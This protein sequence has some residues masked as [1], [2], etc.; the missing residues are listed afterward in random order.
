MNRIVNNKEFYNR[1]LFPNIETKTGKRLSETH[2]RYIVDQVSNAKASI[3]SKLT[4]G[5]ALKELTDLFITKLE[6][7]KPTKTPLPEEVDTREHSKKI[8]G[9]PYDKSIDT[10]NLSKEYLDVE[11]AKE[12]NVTKFLGVDNLNDIK[13]L[14]KISEPLPP[15]DKTYILLDTKYRILDSDGTKK[16]SWNISLTLNNTQGVTN[17]LNEL[18]NITSIKVLPFRIPNHTDFLTEFRRITLLIEELVSQS[19]IGQESRRFH[20]VFKTAADTITYTNWLDLDPYEMNEGVYT[21]NKP[22]TLI[23]KITI[24]F[25]N[26]LESLTFLTDRYDST[27]NFGNPATITTIASHGLVTGDKVIFEGF[28]SSNPNRTSI[29]INNLNRVTGFIA[30]VTGLTTFTIP[31]NLTTALQEAN[32]TD[33]KSVV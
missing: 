13:K 21:F 24:S 15:P 22:F 12:A 18:K 20:F 25:A 2:K 3:F 32:L 11:P 17:S 26:P 33:R 8:L 31:V 6:L 23:N 7:D 16:Y 19:F 28:I 14:A 4:P 9:I 29:V 27:T 5:K 1:I 10:I 30:T